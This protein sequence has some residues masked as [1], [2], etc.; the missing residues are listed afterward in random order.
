MKL[1]KPEEF[2]K[3]IRVGNETYHICF[4]PRLVED[5]MGV[6]DDEMKLIVLSR[7]QSLE[8]LNATFWHEILHAFEKEYKITLGHR[9]INK[10]EW[11]LLEVARQLPD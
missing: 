11:C 8:E 6:C 1:L 3:L 9:T 10:L 2:P 5:N 4:A 7:K